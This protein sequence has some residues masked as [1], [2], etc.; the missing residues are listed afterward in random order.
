MSDLRTALEEA[1]DKTPLD[2][3]ADPVTAAEPLEPSTESP[4]QGLEQGSDAGDSAAPTIENSE[5]TGD[6]NAAAETEGRKRDAQG[7]FAP[8]EP[9]KTEDAGVIAAPKAGEPP[10]QPNIGDKAPNS[11][12]PEIRAEWDKLPES[13]RQTVATRE[14]QIQ[15]VLNETAEARKFAEAISKT[16][17]PYQAMLQAEGMHPIGMVQD[18]L[19]TA[20]ALRT[21]PPEHKAQLLAAIVRKF[22]IDISMLDL[23]LSGQAVQPDPVQSQVNNLVQQQL[24]PIQQQLQQFQQMQYQQQYA[25]AQQNTQKV[26]NFI[27]SQPYGND[28]RAAMADIIEA[29]MRSGRNVSIQEAYDA[30]CYADPGIRGL[31]QQQMQT[32]QLQNRAQ[33]AARAKTA[34]VSLSGAPSAGNDAVGQA[35]SVRAAIEHALSRG[36][37]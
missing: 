29:G 15:Q 37:R 7:K 17:Q 26:E 33:A 2:T 8:N 12:K 21:S 14:R 23:A 25:A 20:Q 19:Q 18:L 28:V 22:G 16:I 10:K 35:D 31:M 1:M 3:A 24:A 30:A 34:A 32:Q 9:K 4:D 36:S 6:L 11:W 27:N 13:V 5:I